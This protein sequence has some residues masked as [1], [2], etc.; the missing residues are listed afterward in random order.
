MAMGRIAQISLYPKQ[1]SKNLN[2]GNIGERLRSPTCSVTRAANPRPCSSPKG[3]GKARG[4]GGDI[5]ANALDSSS[6]FAVR[7][8]KRQFRKIR[9]IAS[10]AAREQGDN[11]DSLLNLLN[12]VI[13]GRL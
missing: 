3:E 2:F 1:L 7:R 11:G 13:S 9:A 8:D 6:L 5:K 4:A 12:F 10:R